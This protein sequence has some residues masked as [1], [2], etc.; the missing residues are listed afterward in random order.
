MSTFDNIDNLVIAIHAS[1]E[2]SDKRFVF[3]VTGGGSTALS[4]LMAYPGAS[5]T[6]MEFNYTYSCESTQEYVNRDSDSP[7]VIKSFAS[8]DT[9]KLLA[10]ASLKRSLKLLTS[11]TPDLTNLV[12]L[13]GAVGIGATASLASKTWKRGEHRIFI[14]LTTNDK[15]ITFS[16]NLF[17][18]TEGAPFRTRK[19]EDD[20]CGILIVCITAFECGLLNKDSLIAFMMANGLDEKDILLISD[21]HIK[22]PLEYLLDNDVTNVLCLPQS[23]GTLVKISN[24]P[25]HHLGQYANKP[26]IVALSGSFNPLHPGHTNALKSSLELCDSTS[27]GIYELS[28]FNVD[29]P[30]LTIIDLMMRLDHFFNQSFPVL[31][32]NTPRFVDKARVYPGLS[33]VIGVDTLLRLI[34]PKYTDGSIDLMTRLL[35]DMTDKGTEFFVLPRT[36]GVA[37]IPHIQLEASEL[38]RYSMVQ[39][40][41]PG[42]LRPFFKEITENEYK[43]VSSS[44]LRNGAVLNA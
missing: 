11:Q 30:P 22:N 14:A 17:K 40:R 37:K 1:T 10:Y 19:Q 6:V 38:L 9:A 35:K 8:L 13:T 42:I 39:Y 5:N 25:I 32:T 41:V 15:E 27:Q 26:K 44:A 12:K 4:H 23:N 43:D 20:L 16:L 24:V 33:Y 31:L 7:F 18:G 2:A 29:K 3:G 21:I 28:V 34:D 36:F